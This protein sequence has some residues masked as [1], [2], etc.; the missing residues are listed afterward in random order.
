M[1]ELPE[2]ETVCRGIAPLITGSSIVSVVQRRP[3]LRIPFPQG[4]SRNREGRMVTGIERRAK[5]ILFTLDNGMVLLVHLGMSGS[6]VVSESKN[7]QPGK[8][9]HVIIRFKDGTILT[10][11]DPRRF[12]L[13]TL[14]SK[15][16]IKK[17]PLLRRLGP[18]PLGR[19]FTGP[20]LAS[21]LSGRKMA[22]K[23]AVLDQT[24]VAGLGNIY[25]C[26]ALYRA[27]ISPRRSANS[28]KGLRAHRLAIAIRNVLDDAIDAG[29]STLRDYVQSTGSVG[30][31]QHKFSVYGCENSPCPN[32]VC[33]TGVKRI[34]QS[35]RS[36]FF[37]SRHQR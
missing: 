9:D 17:H 6:L 16:S 19:D 25:A 8:H 28:I 1:P 30:Y 29:G 32:C 33:S 36:T 18:E 21:A 7:I 3:S 37:C 20:I 12:G 34:V 23:V 15:A 26:E 13:M 14:V 22:I 2:V 24:I 35:G 10:Y 5:Y 11:T 4:F 31:F 27:G